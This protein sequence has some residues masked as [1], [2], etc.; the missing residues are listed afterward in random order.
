M[1]TG[2]KAYYLFASLALFLFAIYSNRNALHAF[3][4]GIALNIFPL[5]LLP[6]VSMDI[7]RLA[8]MPLAYMPITCAG[9]AL[10]VRNN[11]RLPRSY[12]LLLTLAIVYCVYAFFTTVIVGGVTVANLAYWFAWP[13]NFLIFF[14]AAAFFSR[15]D[16]ST[17]NKVIKSTVTVL[18]LGCLVGLMRYALGIGEDANFMP[19]V[20][21][22]GTVVFVAMIF[23][24]LLYIYKEERKSRSWL[25]FCV[26]CIALALALTFSR[27][28]I[29]GLLAGIVLYYMRFTLSGLLKSAAAL[30]LI[31]AF[32][33]SGIA[34]KSL[35]RL[36]RVSVTTQMLL[37]GED[38]NNSMSDY[39][40]VM[41]LKGALATAKDNF[42]FG[43]GLGLENYR[44]GFHKASDYGHDSKSHNFY[45]SYF[46][47][48]GI[49]GF[50]LLLAILFLISRKLYPLS[51]RHKAFKVSFLVIAIMMTMNEYIL[52]PEIW[53]F[54]G[55]LAGMS[56]IPSGAAAAAPS[57]L[58]PAGPAYLAHPTFNR[59]TNRNL[60]G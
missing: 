52:L 54:Y 56:Y 7:A 22:N 45:I 13:L 50:S 43:T 3:G 18:V 10:A 28:G 2:L 41:L 53:F 57:S 24:L 14:S 55:M 30:L 44:K 39:N 58:A 59:I 15:V 25:V 5:A 23:P 33:F 8:G 9:L 6:D 36:E 4:Y 27:S 20:N 31:T 1:L 17:A 51:S 29:I 19:V 35:Q 21:R 16:K 38:L 49:A 11:I 37:H 47:E 12:S 42:W 32:A 40:R 34:D 48:L 26:G 60:N 46:A